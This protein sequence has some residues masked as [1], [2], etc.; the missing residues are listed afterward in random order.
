MAKTI[1]VYKASNGDWVVKRDGATK[2]S[3]TKIITFEEIKE[4]F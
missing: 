3:G 4:D 2:A 1:R